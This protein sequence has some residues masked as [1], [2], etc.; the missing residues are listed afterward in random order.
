[1]YFNKSRYEFH[2]FGRWKLDLIE[3]H[4]YRKLNDCD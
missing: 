3:I 1:M 4:M 2:P